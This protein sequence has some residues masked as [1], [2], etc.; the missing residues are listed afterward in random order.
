M[1]SIVTLL[2]WLCLVLGGAHRLE[3]KTDPKGAKTPPPATQST[4][5]LETSVAELQENIKDLRRNISS[6]RKIQGDANLTSEEKKQWRTKAQEY[7]Q[8]CESYDELLTKINANKLPK[9]EVSRRFLDDR[10][11]FQREV[12][13]LRQT[14]QQP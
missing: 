1:S 6:W 3:A 8:E 9:S 11:T 2:L 14:L 13:Y 4:A 5:E 12:Q 7:L 10:K